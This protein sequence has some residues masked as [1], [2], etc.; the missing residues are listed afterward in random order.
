MTH[1]GRC[2]VDIRHSSFI[3]F[4]SQAPRCSA[5]RSSKRLIGCSVKAVCRSAR[6]PPGCGSAEARSP[7]SPADAAD[8]MDATPAT[9]GHL[10]QDINPRRN[11]VPAV[12]TMSTCHA[13]S[14]AVVTSSCGRNC[15]WRWNPCDPQRKSEMPRDKETG[16]QRD[17]VMKHQR[18]QR[19][20]SLSPTL[21][22][23]LSVTRRRSAYQFYRLFRPSP[24]RRHDAMFAL[25]RR[26]T[27]CVVDFAKRPLGHGPARGGEGLRKRTPM[28]RR[29]GLALLAGAHQPAAS[30]R[31]I[32]RCRI[33]RLCLRACHQ[34]N[35]L[36]RT[37]TLR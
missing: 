21:L 34:L 25:G 6:L 12:A 2:V 22:V 3:H 15:G 16:R 26:G 35:G 36:S 28:S 10:R 27:N 29:A 11:V 13:S 32:S 31:L 5:N 7:R 18:V 14:V 1:G 9:T 8:C 24:S 20:I 4:Q 23:S 33:V 37:G 17:K 30:D 19:R